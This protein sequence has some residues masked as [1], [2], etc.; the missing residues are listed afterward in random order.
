MEH[1]TEGKLSIQKGEVAHG[2][3]TTRSK[4]RLT[5]MPVFLSHRSA[6]APVPSPVLTEPP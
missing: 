5:A 4:S 3:T 2:Y 1:F 6:S